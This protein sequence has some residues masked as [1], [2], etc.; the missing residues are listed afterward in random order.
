MAAAFVRAIIFTV[1]SRWF[2]KVCNQ[3]FYL[4]LSFCPK[5]RRPN[6]TRARWI[7]H[8]RIG[9]KSQMTLVEKTGVL[10]CLLHTRNLED[11]ATQRP[12]PSH[13]DRTMYALPFSSSRHFT[14]NHSALRFGIPRRMDWLCVFVVIGKLQ[15]SRVLTL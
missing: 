2:I 13:L 10:L 14:Q 3:Y 12:N 7:F 8:L 6:G 4:E 9:L 1:Q 5:K 11:F 15:R